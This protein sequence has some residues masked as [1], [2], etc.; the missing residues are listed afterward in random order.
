MAV[1]FQCMTKSTTNKKKIKKNKITD[2]NNKTRGSGATWNDIHNHIVGTPE[3]EEKNERG[4]EIIWSNNNFKNSL[5]KE[6]DIQVQESLTEPKMNPN[7]L[8]P[9]NGLIKTCKR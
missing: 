2:F 7:M 1:S 8:I 5:K 9:T 6:T 4:R 3:K